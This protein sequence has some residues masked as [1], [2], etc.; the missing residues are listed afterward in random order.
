MTNHEAASVPAAMFQAWSDFW[1]KTIEANS[2]YTKVL[3]E[4]ANG[5]GPA[6]LETLRRRWLESLGKSMDA[7]LRTPAFLEMIHHHFD[8]MTLA[9]TNADDVAKEVARNTGFPHLDDIAGLFERLQIG[10][11]AILGRLAAIERRLDAV[12]GAK[13]TNGQRKAH[14]GH[15]S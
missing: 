13:K 9:K 7:Y 2:D 1:A 15:Q 3:L 11:V 8:A 5:D 6:D 14:S 10:Q 4:S 12:E